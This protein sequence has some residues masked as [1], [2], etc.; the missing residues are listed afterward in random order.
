MNI[1]KKIERN[2]SGLSPEIQAMVRAA[3]EQTKAAE[4]P[5]STDKEA[6][7]VLKSLARPTSVVTRKCKN[8]KREFQTDYAFKRYC[9]RNCLREALKANGILW[10]EYKPET[11][12]WHGEPPSTIYPETLETLKIWARHILGL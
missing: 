2:L 12:R 7:L 10:D 4:T 11:E 9:T 3:Q 6:E 8:C 1:D 5:E